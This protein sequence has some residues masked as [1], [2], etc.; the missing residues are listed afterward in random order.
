VI[1]VPGTRHSRSRHLRA[2]R[3]APQTES[4]EV[5]SRTGSCDRMPVTFALASEVSGES[6]EA[7]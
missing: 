2:P 7:E 5:A 3:H 4:I 1:R 6:S